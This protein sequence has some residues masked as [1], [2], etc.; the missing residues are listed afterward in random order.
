MIVA[1]L[2]GPHAY[3]SDKS[4]ENDG[5]VAQYGLYLVMGSIC[6]KLFTLNSEDDQ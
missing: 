1:V 5:R 2:C 6:C 4:V 3:L